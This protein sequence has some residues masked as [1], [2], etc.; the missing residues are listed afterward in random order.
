MKGLFLFALFIAVLVLLFRYL[1]KREVEAFLDAD[2]VEFQSFKAAQIE[3]TEPDPIMARAE[4]FAALN[5]AV[6]KL[7]QPERQEAAASHDAYEAPD[8]TLFVLKSQT[9]DEVTRNML[10]LLNKVVPPR[11]TVL[12]DVPLSDFV[13]AEQDNANSTLRLA[14]TTIRYLLC[15]SSDMSVICG[16]QHRDA[17]ATGRQSI[18]FVKSVFG[19]IGKP[20]LE[21]PVS[22]DISE[23]E[24]R[25]QLD[26]VL[27]P[28]ELRECPRCGETMSI[29]KAMKGKTAGTIYWVC[30]QFPGCRGV[31]KA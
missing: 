20:L 24:I 12:L 6:V 15:D 9:F 21:F 4:A 7:K 27:L 8:P 2:M 5:P 3:K 17:G 18:D 23:H 1:R 30:S 13:G 26:P 29:R 25:D 19:D 14:N 10:E 22:N 28:R 31:I 11:F 16:L